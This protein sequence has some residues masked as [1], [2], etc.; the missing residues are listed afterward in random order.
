V[1]RVGSDCTGKPRG[2]PP[3]AKPAGDA[4]EL[5]FD[6]QVVRFSGDAVTVK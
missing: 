3:S 6:C 1:M 4:T 5:E 2:A